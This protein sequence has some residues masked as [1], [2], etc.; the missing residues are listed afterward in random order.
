MNGQAGG[1]GRRSALLGGLVYAAVAVAVVA[2]V[3]A[4]TGF[5][6]EIRGADA[7]EHHR[8]IRVVAALGPAAGNPTFATDEPSIRYSPY[9]LAVA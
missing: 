3:A 6:D 8:A 9:T 2:L 4:A 7:W 5:R 1:A